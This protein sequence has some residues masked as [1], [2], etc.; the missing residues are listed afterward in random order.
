MIELEYHYFASLHKLIDLCI[1]YQ[2]MLTSQ[3]G[4]QVLCASWYKNATLPIY[5][6]RPHLSSTVS[7][8]PAYNF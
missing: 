6:K 3:K 7:L 2:W 4:R 5:P 8:Y 1:E